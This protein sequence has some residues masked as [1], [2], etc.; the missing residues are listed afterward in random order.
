M[1]R[2]KGFPTLFSLWGKNFHIA[3]TVEQVNLV[4]NEN[5]IISLLALLYHIFKGTKNSLKI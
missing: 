2:G 5:L 4:R 1:T 3:L